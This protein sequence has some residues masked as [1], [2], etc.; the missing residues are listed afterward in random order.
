MLQWETDPENLSWLFR[1]DACFSRV[2]GFMQAFAGLVKSNMMANS[3]LDH[4]HTHLKISQRNLTLRVVVDSEDHLSLA[5]RIVQDLYDRTHFVDA[6]GPSLPESVASSFVLQDCHI[7]TPHPLPRTNAILLTCDKSLRFPLCLATMLG[8]INSELRRSAPDGSAPD[9]SAP[10]RSVPGSR[11]KRSR[12][13]GPLQED[14]F[15]S[16]NQLLL[17]FLD[18]YNSDKFGSF[19][20]V[21]L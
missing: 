6:R 20:K 7:Y 2:P 9:R 3:C 15:K 17:S 1:F 5:T 19:G 18:A 12:K 11:A 21:G 13:Q 8:W 14:Q 4:S 10:D 16:S